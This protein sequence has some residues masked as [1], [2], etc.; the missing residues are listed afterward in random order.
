M[1]SSVGIIRCTTYDE[2][3]VKKAI[4]TITKPFNEKN[5]QK[6][7][8]KKVAIY[9]DF[10]L[11]NISIVKET[12]NYL[13]EAG[14]SKIIAG[15]SIFN[16]ELPQEMKNLLKEEN[17]DFIDFR[18]DQYEKL[19]VPLTKEKMP[20][21]FRGY[22]FISPIQYSREK[23]IEKMGIKGSR[24]L[25]HSFLPLSLTNA[26]YIIPIIKMK[27]S[28]VSQLGGIVSSMLSLA[29][30]ITRNQ[31]LVNKLKRKFEKS[32]LEIYSLVK[33]RI[34]FGIVDGIYA[35]ITDNDELNK[36]NVILFSEDGLALD[37][38]S[39]V[40]IGYRS[41]DIKTNKVG[42]DMNLGSGLFIH[43]SLYGDDFL[44][45]RK[46]IKNKLKFRTRHKSIPYINEQSANLITKKIEQFCPTGAILN[47][48]G[49]Y[50]IDKSQC[51]S[52]MF[53]VQIAPD[54]F[55]I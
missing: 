51:A 52:C 31:I 4:E 29:P 16:K 20:E 28:P 13:E 24:I 9:F 14:A 33:D 42:D 19:A 48:N 10:P 22:A 41:R 49:K 34:L 17:I 44:G 6:I 27:V 25:K 5:K 8:G 39:A 18:N 36:M 54:L 2:N 43:V 37:S 47:T 1:N 23:Q 55:K 46:E 38:V 15:T 3:D 40:L 7:K 30:T 21:H 11:P 12:I 45:F 32:I 50:E 35:D 26:D 53:C